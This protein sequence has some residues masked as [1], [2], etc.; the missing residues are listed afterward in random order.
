MLA[1]VSYSVHSYL[2]LKLLNKSMN[3][4]FSLRIRRHV[5]GYLADAS[6]RFASLYLES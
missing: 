1:T 5:D 3:E 4:D 2:L 6:E